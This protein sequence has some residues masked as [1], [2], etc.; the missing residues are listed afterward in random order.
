VYR[1]KQWHHRFFSLAL[2]PQSLAAREDAEA[3][4]APVNAGFREGRGRWVVE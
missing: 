1:A 4:W 3:W 2:V